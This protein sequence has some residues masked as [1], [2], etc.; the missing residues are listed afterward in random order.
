MFNRREFLKALGAGTS[1]LLWPS[2]AAADSPLGK[3]RLVVVLLRGALDGLAAVPCDSDPAYQRLRGSLASQEG[4]VAPRLDGTFSL[5]PSLAFCHRLYQA[6]DFA[7]VHACGLPYQGR[8]HFDAQ[9]C[10]ENGTATP[11]GSRTGWLNRAVGSLGD[12]QGLGLTSSRPLLIRGP[13]PF[14]TWSPSAHGTTQPSLAQ[15]VAALYRQD[16]RLGPVFERALAMQQMA[17][18]D[19]D[20]G[21]LLKDTLAAAAQFLAAADGPQIAMVEDDGWD[22]HARQNAVLS[23][24]L[25][26]LDG[27]LAA[28]HGKLGERWQHTAVMVITEFGRTVAVNGTGG[29]DHGTASCILLA[30]GAIRGGRVHGQWPGLARLRDDRDLIAAQD[31][32]A[33][34]K[35]VLRDHLGLDLDPLAEQVFPDSRQVAPLAGLIG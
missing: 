18:T 1:L 26:Q 16:P 12:T 2:L 23:R 10:L 34:L 8:S 27:G 25:E 3:R 5:H 11:T 20:S 4:V 35:G 9:E 28:L 15:R 13:A 29:T 7:V 33:V 22:T 32:R 24:K 19:I 30:G 17:P 6:G 14:A 21:G 31:T